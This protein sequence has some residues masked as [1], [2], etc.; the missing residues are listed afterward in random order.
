MTTSK[1]RVV[2]QSIEK[3]A[4]KRETINGWIFADDGVSVCLAITIK[5]DI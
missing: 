1:S 3:E 5:S 2:A 4:R